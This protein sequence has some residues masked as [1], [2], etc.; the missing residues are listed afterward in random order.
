MHKLTFTLKQHTPLIHFQADQQG[1][2]L[3]A[4]EVKP[5]FDRFLLEKLGEG[6]YGK[7]VTI[8]RGK[9]WLI[10][11]AKYPALNYKLKIKSDTVSDVEDPPAPYFG[12]KVGEDKSEPMKKIK[13]RYESINLEFITIIENLFDKNFVP[14]FE[15]FILVNNFGT[16]SGKGF[17]SFSVERVNGHLI[18]DNTH[19]QLSKKFK[20]SFDVHVNTSV[21]KSPA[22]E[23]FS[24]IDLFCK[25]IRA[26]YNMNG[27][28]IKPFIFLYAKEKEKEWQWEKK[29]IKEAFFSNN[30]RY[31]PPEYKEDNSS[32]AFYSSVKKID[33]NLPML[34]G[35]LGLATSQNWDSSNTIVIQNKEKKID[36]YASPIFFKPIRNDDRF[37]VYFDWLESDKGIW[38]KTFLC[39]VKGKNTSDLK[40]TV[41]NKKDFNPA[42][43]MDF[44]VKNHPRHHFAFKIDSAY[45]SRKLTALSQHDKD[46]VI[47]D[48]I[49]DGKPDHFDFSKHRN[50]IGKPT[51]SLYSVVKSQLGW[52]ENSQLF[53]DEERVKKAIDAMN[54][55]ALHILDN[56]FDQLNQKYNS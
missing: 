11:G 15:E 35:V 56:I 53:A 54:P 6:S 49:T 33:G 31:L 19:Y 40:L 26:G 42:G 52:N 30:D 22:R 5:R 18:P 23:L 24:Y 46:I 1:A 17:G 37:T 4:S 39:N 55:G 38:G 2:T 45:L 8:A 10:K 7:G 43:F 28:Y 3:R 20:Y 48:V 12:N 36:R 50:E 34:R 16:R 29:S 13:K 41:P 32:P 9:G 14:Q 47:N 27:L 44:I 25:I 21:K 51:F